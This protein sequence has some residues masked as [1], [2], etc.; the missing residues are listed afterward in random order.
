MLGKLKERYAAKSLVNQG[1]SLTLLLALKYV[2]CMI[3]SSY[4]A[5][6]E[7][8][9]SQLAA[10]MM[11]IEEPLKVAL[12]LVRISD[13]KNYATVVTFLKTIGTQE[14]TRN[15]TVMQLLDECTQFT[16]LATPK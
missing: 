4:T 13:H 11:I 15:H 8:H 7:E 3:I 14:V 10:M 1:S 6:I 12:L 16:G 9:M 2:K 5:H